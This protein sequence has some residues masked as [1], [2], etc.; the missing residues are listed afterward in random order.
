MEVP[1]LGAYTT[2]TATQDLSLICDLHHSSQ[3]RQVLSKA[4]DRTHVLMDTSWVLNPLSLSRNSRRFFFLPKFIC[5]VKTW[6]RLC[7]VQFITTEDSMSQL[8][9]PN[10]AVYSMSPRAWVVPAVHH[11][12]HC[13]LERGLHFS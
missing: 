10:P 12:C 5:K 9:G 1:R 13:H 6:K 11:G 3:Q 4:R 8:A 7:L 2:A